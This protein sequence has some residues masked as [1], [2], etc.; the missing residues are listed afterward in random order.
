LLTPLN[1]STLKLDPDEVSSAANPSFPFSAFIADLDV[2]TDGL[3]ATLSQRFF[4]L[5][6]ATK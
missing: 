3:T 4:T 2:E 1:L 5:H 6:A